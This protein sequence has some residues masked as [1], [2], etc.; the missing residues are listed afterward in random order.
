MQH[1]LARMLPIGREQAMVYRLGERMPPAG[2]MADHGPIWEAVS[3]VLPAQGTLQARVNVQRDFYLMALT[4][5]ASTVTAAGGFRVQMYDTKKQVRFA[6]R[7]MRF[8]NLFGDCG[9]PSPTGPFFIREPY[10][11]D[12]PDSQIM[13]VVQNLESVINTVQIA[14]Y[15]QALRF[16]EA[17]TTAREF[18]G[19]SVSSAFPGMKP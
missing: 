16:N 15:G 5:L 12:Q 2:E 3:F 9:P 17:N 7:G 6:D 8:Q 14:L 13:V 11:F 19:G 4:G 10:H 18:P 1:P